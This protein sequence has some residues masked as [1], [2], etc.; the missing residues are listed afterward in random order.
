VRTEAQVFTVHAPSIVCPTKTIKL[1]DVT[2]NIINDA[3]SG[4]GGNYWAYDAMTRH[5]QIWFVNIV[6][7]VNNYCAE[8]KD[9]GTFATQAGVRSPGSFMVN[10]SYINGGV[11]DG[12]EVG[13]FS[14][15]AVITVIGTFNLNDPAHWPA[16]GKGNGGTTLND[17]C[18]ITPPAGTINNCPHL[19]HTWEAHYFANGYQ[20]TGIPVWGWSYIGVDHSTAPDAGT[21]A[22]RWN[23]FYNGDSGD[24]LDVD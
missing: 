2:Y 17:G 9:T 8:I 19:I 5:L 15:G 20:E 6:N 11:V 24:I 18:V 3:D 10:G 14:G 16:S 1:V 4:D 13:T 21:S 7:G 12:T 23:N 22:G